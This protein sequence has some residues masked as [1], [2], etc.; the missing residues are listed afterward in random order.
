MASCVST[1]LRF[2]IKYVSKI[3][4]DAMIKMSERL[5]CIKYLLRSL[6]HIIGNQESRMMAIPLFVMPNFHRVRAV[7][8]APILLFG[9][10]W[11]G[12]S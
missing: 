1:Y 3:L 5:L 12:F 4:K 8:G 10:P 6:D 11:R 2:T 9:K 7:M